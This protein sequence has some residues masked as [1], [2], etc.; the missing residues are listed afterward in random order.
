[1]RIPSSAL[2]L[3]LAMLQLP[4]FAQAQMYRWV[5]DSGKVHYSDQM[6]SSAAKSLQKLPASTAK[7]TAALPYAL[8]QAVEH[9][10]V[11][12]YTSESCKETCA[13]AREL[14]GKRGV[15]FSDIGVKE[16]AD[17]AQ[18]KKIS[19]GNVVPVLVVGRE[20]YSGF[21]SRIYHSALDTAMYPA[22]S[23]LPPGV[24]ARKVQAKPV[25]EPAPA[26]KEAEAQ[27]EPPP[28]NPSSPDSPK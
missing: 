22:N 27:P 19:G 13:Q 12:L 20:V 7:G 23:L 6:P 25:K 8:Q 17:L 15:P 28:Q 18:L 1:M 10:P 24:Q 5:D 3:L 16:D 26:A 4:L 11:T 21:E 9:F 2:L 14:L